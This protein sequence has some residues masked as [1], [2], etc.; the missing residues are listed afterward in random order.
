MGEYH[1]LHLK[2]DRGSQRRF[3]PKYIENTFKAIRSTFSFLEIHSNRRC[4][5]HI[6]SVILG[7]LESFPNY[8]GFRIIF[9]KSSD[10]I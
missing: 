9:P 10:A 7:Q 5:I 2:S 4:K 8:Q 6:F 1:D 3:P